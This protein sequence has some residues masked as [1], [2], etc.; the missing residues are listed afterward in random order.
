MRNLNNFL[1]FFSREILPVIYSFLVYILQILFFFIFLL[2]FPPGSILIL[3][4]VDF[5]KEH[6]TWRFFEREDLY[7][8]ADPSNMGH[9]DDYFKFLETG[10]YRCFF[11]GCFL[12]CFFWFPS[13]LWTLGISLYSLYC[14][15]FL[16][17]MKFD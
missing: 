5:I 12:C 8:R 10:G 13:V 11:V 4:K 16:K 1:N 14:V 7:F 15:L 9:Q 3:N 6:Q 2:I 17:K